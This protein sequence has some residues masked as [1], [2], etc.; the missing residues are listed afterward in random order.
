MCDNITSLLEKEKCLE[1][2]TI[3]RYH[4]LTAV[5]LQTT[6]M[7][8]WYTAYPVF[9]V[10][11]FIL[12]LSCFVVPYSL[13][14]SY[15]VNIAIQNILSAVCSIVDHIIFH[16]LNN[17]MHQHS[18]TWLHKTFRKVNNYVADCYLYF[19]TLTILFAYLGVAR[20]LVFKKIM[21]KKRIVVAASCF[22]YLWCAA[23]ALKVLLFQ[24][25][26]R[27]V[28]NFTLKVAHSTFSVALYVVMIALYTLT[29]LEI[30]KRRTGIVANESASRQLYWKTLKSIVAF[31]TLPNIAYAITLSHFICEIHLYRLINLVP[32]A[33]SEQQGCSCQLPCNMVSL[34]ARAL[35][36]VRL[37]VTSF[38]A[39]IAFH[40]YRVATMRILQKALNSFKGTTNVHE[41]H[42]SDSND[43]I[44]H[45]R[46]STPLRNVSET[47][48]AQVVI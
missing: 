38:T 30:V 9:V 47:E 2:M 21:Q 24:W 8:R 44:F 39:L 13:A 32:P 11:L 10:S 1:Q 42:R 28:A 40:D 31:C 6:V 23:L 37:L 5:V 26:D 25:I 4:D 17:D 29:L 27:P 45:R 35:L 12:Y 34:I 16:L 43:S 20:P 14:R 22:L 19:S 48:K 15:C 18:N 7:V 36:T 46:K 3:Q 33:P 41:I